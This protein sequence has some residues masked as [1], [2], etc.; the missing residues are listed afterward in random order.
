METKGKRTKQFIIERALAL[1]ATKGY[2]AVTMKDICESCQMS[3]GGVYRYFA[4]TKEIFTEA[5]A[6]DLE[7]SRAI[8]SE[9]IQEGVPADRIM[10]VYFM[11]EMEAIFSKEN[12]LYFAIHEFAFA[13]PEQKTGLNKRMEDSL[14]ILT[15]IFEYGQKTQVFKFFDRRQIATHILY[16][17]DSLK[18]SS[19][20]LEMDKAM[21]EDQIA[22]LKSLY[23]A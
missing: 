11:Q 18:T 23:M 7:L 21:V 15:S 12:G 6:T 3:R 8:V 16:F 9:N 2:I 17:M 14:E 10:D 20:I 19:S 1:F 13:E 4:S 22:L 5:L